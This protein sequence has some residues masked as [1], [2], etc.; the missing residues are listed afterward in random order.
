MCALFPYTTL[1]R[2]GLVTLMR[3]RPT[4]GSAAVPTTVMSGW[5]LMISVIT[6]RINAES[7]T[8]STLILF[9][10]TSFLCFW[11]RARSE[12][13]T[14]ELQSQFHLVCRPLLDTTPPDTDVRT[15]S[16]HDALP[17][18]VG[19]LDEVAPHQRIGGRSHHRHVRLAVDDFG[20][21][22]A[23]QRRVVD[24]QH[25]DLVRAHQLPLLLAQGEI[26]RAHV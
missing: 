26:G 20:H 22:A 14:S 11:P 23:Y 6:L 5:L 18:W 17:I 12:E 13:H 7:S 25:L 10:L 9:A 16:L 24:A 19:D 15:L 21:H 4:S 2:S 1:F 3:S 8:H